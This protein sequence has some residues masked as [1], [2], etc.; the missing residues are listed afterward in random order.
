MKPG[1][2]PV[3]YLA[4]PTAVGKSAIALALAE[5]IGGE[6]VSVDSMQV[7]RGLDI[8]T[9]KPAAA[10]RARVRHH[11]IDVI[12]LTSGFDASQFVRLAAAAVSDI[13]ARGRPPIFCGGTGLYFKAWCEGLHEIPSGDPVLRAELEATPLPILLDELAGRD[14]A[15]FETIDRRNPRRVVRALEVI[16]LTG[17]PLSAQRT[18]RRAGA[19]GDLA[20]ATRIVVF[21]RAPDDL[22]TRINARVDAMFAAG[23]IEETRRLLSAGLGENRTAMQALGYRQVIEHLRGERDL[24]GTIA[25]VKLKTWQFA[26]RQMTWFR[27]QTPARWIDLETLDE[28]QSGVLKLLR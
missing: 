28:P 12:D 23:L 1:S 13:Q 3:L 19:L 18:E 24:A 14:R 22:R 6:I 2:L 4:G 8:G 9:A 26:R 5:Q 27:H 16:R 10:D 20:G 21:R 17:R 15:T 11:L 7:Y 25:L